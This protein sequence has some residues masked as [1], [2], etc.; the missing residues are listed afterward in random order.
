LTTND[1]HGWPAALSSHAFIAPPPTTAPKPWEEF[2]AEKA[3][4]LW[5]E[6][7]RASAADESAPAWNRAGWARSAPRD[8]RPALASRRECGARMRA[9]NRTAIRR[10]GRARSAG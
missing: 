1:L 7:V 8:L 6:R 4:P 2:P 5:G 10:L 3:L 9:A